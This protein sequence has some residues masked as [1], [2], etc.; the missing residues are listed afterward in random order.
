M[1]SDTER[2]KYYQEKLHKRKS[3][4]HS[5][6]SKELRAKLKIKK[7]AILLHLGDSVR[8][9]RGPEKGKDAKVSRVSTVSRKVY[10][11][12]I[13]TKNA[14]GREV[15]IA[16]EASNLLL[17]SLESTPERKEIFSEDAFKKKEAAKEEKKEV[18][19]ED[20][21]SKEVN[22]EKSGHDTTSKT[23]TKSEHKKEYKPEHKHSEHLH[24]G[25]IDKSDKVKV[26]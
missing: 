24:R 16:V 13:V 19:S 12:G 10:L 2:K 23:E 15:P 25:H 26:Q 22:H 9:M 1:K 3:R 6:L 11:E 17:I 5:H 7:R 21:V 8:I 14:R 18:K 20:K 4:L